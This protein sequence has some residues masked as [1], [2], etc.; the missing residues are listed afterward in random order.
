MLLGMTS[1]FSTLSDFR[2]LEPA[3]TKDG[4]FAVQHPIREFSNTHAFALYAIYMPR[5][6]MLAFVEFMAIF[7]TQ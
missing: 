1:F 5:M 7:L 3:R 6:K 2:L 4:K